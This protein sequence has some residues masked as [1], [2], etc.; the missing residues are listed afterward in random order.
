MGKGP[1]TRAVVRIALAV[2][3]TG[4]ALYLLYLIRGVLDLIVLAVFVALGLGPFVEILSRRHVPR[5]VAIL[6]AYL[7][8]FASLVVIGLVAVPPVVKQIDKGVHQLP[9]GIS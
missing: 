8:L 9:A 2:A 3:V 6:L 7:A 4:I 1:S 5:A